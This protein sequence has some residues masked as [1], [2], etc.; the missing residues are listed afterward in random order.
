[1]TN[2]EIIPAISAAAAVLILYFAAKR[3][4]LRWRRDYLCR[5]A[6]RR[7]EKN[8]ADI[9]SGLPNRK[10]IVLNDLLLR[11]GDRLSQIDHVV[12][13]VY[14]IFVIETKSHAGRIHGR[15][16]RENWTQNLAGV[17][18]RIYNPLRQ[19]EG[20]IRCLRRI[21]D[22][23]G[24]L[25]YHSI[26]VFTRSASLRIRRVS[27]GEVIELHE[28]RKRIRRRRRK[29]MK[30]EECAMIAAELRKANVKGR[31]AREEHKAEIKRKWGS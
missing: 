4:F 13:S 9:L 12:V 6:G 21:L 1:M 31:K 17:K 3:A 14:G 25:K 2:D 30:P 26:V 11:N 27:G 28:L 10:Y 24:F 29:V 18:N 20:H 5:R 15:A 19:N 22:D 23:D 8:V 16:T 7:G